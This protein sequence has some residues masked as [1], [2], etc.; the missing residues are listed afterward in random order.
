MQLAFTRD[1]IP[2]NLI[3]YGILNEE[4]DYRVHVGFKTG[5]LWVFPT[6]SGRAAVEEAERIGITPRYPKDPNVHDG[7]GATARGFEIPPILLKDCQEVEIPPDILQEYRPPPW[8]STSVKGRAAQDVAML[9]FQR[10]L[11]TLPLVPTIITNETLQRKGQDMLVT[12]D[13]VIQIKCDYFACHRRANGT[14]KGLF[15]Q[16]HERNP[17][18]QF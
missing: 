13:A 5:K 2:P 3:E 14:T 15:L 9:V 10:G 1:R 17:L 4:S 16:T 6:D 8:E 11:A 18:R 12:R 7:N